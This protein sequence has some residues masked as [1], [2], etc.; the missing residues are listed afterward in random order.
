MLRQQFSS[1]LY[2]QSS[3]VSKM[4]PKVTDNMLPG[5]G[6]G[7][8]QDAVINKYGAMVKSKK[9]GQNSGPMPFHSNLT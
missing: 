4:D 9:F 5:Q 1:L 6:C 3:V 7:T 8:L 2:N